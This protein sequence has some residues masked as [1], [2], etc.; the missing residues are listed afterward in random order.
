VTTDDS[1]PQHQPP[2]VRSAWRRW[3]AALATVL[4]LAL[5]VAGLLLATARGLLTRPITRMA[6]ERLG[7]E[8]VAEGG[9]RI[10][11]G[12]RIR[13]T[14]LGLR[15]AN[16]TWASPG[17]MLRARRLELEIDPRSLFR[18]T[19]IVRRLTAEGLE[20]HL[21]RNAAGENNWTFKVQP[22]RTIR[23][24]PVVFDSIS[25]PGA[26][27]SFAG[28]RLEHPLELAFA[29]LEQRMGADDMLVLDA[30]GDGNGTPLALQVRSGPLANLIE[31]QDFSVNARGHLGEIALGVDAR[32]DSLAT[33]GA[34]QLS[35]SLEAPEASYL[36]SR[37]GLRGLGE[38]PVAVAL[39]VSPATSGK[40]V[41][42]R[43]TGQVG[44]FD[45][46]A[47]GSLAI[48]DE[49]PS[50]GVRGHIAGP[51]MARVAALAGLRGLPAEP[52][53]LELDGH[54]VGKEVRVRAAALELADARLEVAGDVNPAASVE[55]GELSFNLK[56][57]DLVRLAQ[58]FRFR[59][60]LG[61]PIELSGRLHLARA[62]ELR[63]DCRG[64]SN[65][66]EFTAVGPIQL[67]KDG[68]G[69]RLAFTAS[70]A[71]VAPLAAALGVRDPPRGKY[72]SDGDVEWTRDGLRLHSARMVAGAESLTASGMLGRPTFG[73]G[74]D[75]QVDASGPSAARM[76]SRFGYDGVPADRYRVSG[77]VQRLPD[78][79]VLSAVNLEL[80]GARLQ[81][82]GVIGAAPG[83]DG[84]KLAFSASGPSLAQFAGVL[85]QGAWPREPFRVTGSLG[86]V[87]GNL[88]RVAPL[89]L[90]LGKATATASVDADLPLARRSLRFA[91]DA[92]V[93]DLSS[94]APGWD[95][96]QKVRGPVQV[97]LA[98]ARDGDAWKVERLQASGELGQL[99]TRGPITLLP[100]L[101]IDDVQV[102]VHA[103]S[104]RM[105]G[106]AA[107]DQRWPELALEAHARV[108]ADTAAL[109]LDAL[110]GRLAGMAF[111]G[112]AAVRDLKGKPD[113][114]LEFVFPQL[115]LDRLLKKPDQAA[116]AAGR[117]VGAQRG[118]GPVA[119]PT[120]DGARRLIPDAEVVMPRLRSYSGKL[121][122]RAGRLHAF[123]SD[124]SDVELQAALRDGRLR[125]D[126]FTAVGAS[127]RISLKGTLASKGQGIA[128][129]L[130][131]TGS[132][133]LLRPV[134]IGF[135]GADASRYT[136]SFELQ[137]SGARWPELAAALNGRVRLV[138]RGGR[139]KNSLVMA[140][141]N[142]FERQLLSGINPMATKQPTTDV[143]C[144][145][146]LLRAK[147]GV[148]TT[149]PAM[150]M[151]TR[152]VD[153]VSAGSVDLRSEKIDFNFK[154]KARTGLGLS[155]AQLVNPYLKVNGTLASP[156][157][158]ID[159]TGALVN[160]GA[161]FATAGLSV[162][163][164]TLWDRFVHESDPCGAAVAEYDRRAAHAATG[165]TRP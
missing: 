145:V 121:A 115:D 64:T 29:T 39:A 95:N 27:V 59:S 114:A 28:P 17:D 136:A 55:D 74:T 146:Y 60:P 113:V 140:S 35:F 88:L 143:D 46:A 4:V 56:A 110:G 149:E 99:S 156:G 137:S 158:T 162:V 112:R 31:A 10:E 150:V 108:S 147:D 24:L 62:R 92:M 130:A 123:D 37:L 71:D 165:G 23:A 81:L 7:R 57:T 153:I 73:R 42:A 122:L 133:L 164:T 157:V 21:Q 90:A 83:F 129:Q 155:I 3:R 25:L 118:A 43:I 34:T 9:V 50:Y 1:T 134:P 72:S 36:A 38:G 126:P 13:V 94:L 89:Q 66:G 44:E 127:G 97:N 163:A 102:D 160:G 131:G 11:L 22:K 49:V 79:T 135:G 2:A 159:P 86:K 93:P 104:L 101:V 138:G 69:T 68:I 103:P 53:R 152:E 151:R 105:I 47:D 80:S 124:L 144:A 41:Q 33:P 48:T 26:R 120:A 14:A 98:G 132:D 16:S 161:A 85:P 87:A 75:L 40:G 45:V 100:R 19:L 96:A 20:L 52:F 65:Y 82:D 54:G 6:S 106:E 12:R 30:A 5:L 128:V 51:D 78:R 119:A 139:M 70:G 125:V 91:L 18:D 154:I 109:R 8:L 107:L 142:S 116:P 141:T 58:R 61:G 77:R 111:T 15:L 117:V 84:T 148:V 63:V 76:A 67:V 32:V